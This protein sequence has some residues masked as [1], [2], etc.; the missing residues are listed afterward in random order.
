MGPL[1]ESARTSKAAPVSPEAGANSLLH[2]LFVEALQTMHS[3]ELQIAQNL[4]VM[5]QHAT[6]PALREGF[7]KHLGETQIQM[8]RLQE[9]LQMLGAPA[10]SAVCRATHALIEQGAETVARTPAGTAV[11][12]VA[13][14][15]GAQK[16]EHMEIA[17][18]GGLIQLA[19]M[20]NQRYISGLLEA[21]MK[22]EY[23]AD[24]L[25]TLAAESGINSRAAEEGAVM[26]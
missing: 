26:A 15:L 23:G 5:Q 18:Y 11:R 4:P 19:K 3:A 17:A 12:D 6:H 21:S 14:I 9:A 8:R 25:L 2:D 1:Q 7:G 10:G 24:K 13:L 20:L 16:I 22:E